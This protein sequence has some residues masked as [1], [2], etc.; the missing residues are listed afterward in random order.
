MP[1]LLSSAGCGGNRVTGKEAA[2]D[3]AHLRVNRTQ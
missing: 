3:G 1:R 2:H